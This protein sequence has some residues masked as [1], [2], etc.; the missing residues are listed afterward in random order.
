[1]KRSYWLAGAL[2]LALGLFYYF[3]AALAARIQARLAPE[4][5]LYGVSGTLLHGHAAALRVR[6]LTLQK[7]EWDWRPLAVLIARFSA[8]LRAEAQERALEGRVSFAPG[9]RVRLNDFTALLD[10]AQVGPLLGMQWLP[11][12]GQIDVVL[13]ELRVKRQQPRHAEGRLALTGARWRLVQPAAA[14]GDFNAELSTED[15]EIVATLS[16]GAGP[17]KLSGTAKLGKAG[18]YEVDLRL[19]PD[20][21]AEPSLINMLRGLGQPDAQ[22]AY[23]LQLKGKLPAPA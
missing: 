13:D 17:L 20:G 1:M 16:S 23:R 21:N 9:G 4:L 11:V 12:E 19:Q 7:A 22:G 14:L 5:Q 8:D 15:G 3:P 6:G 18:D 10:V 2:G